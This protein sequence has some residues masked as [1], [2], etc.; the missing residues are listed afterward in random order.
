[1]LYDQGIHR[2]LYLNKAAEIERPSLPPLT[3]GMPGTLKPWEGP[4]IVIDGSRRYEGIAQAC[5]LW[6]VNSSLPP[7]LTPLLSESGFGARMGNSS[8]LACLGKD[9]LGGKDLPS[10]SIKRQRGERSS[11][12]EVDDALGTCRESGSGGQALEAE[13]D[14]LKREL[15]MAQG[16]AKEWQSMYSELH[17][18][19]V[20]SA[21]G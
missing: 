2:I 13:V 21:L 1:V 10:G 5:G 18:A 3:K 7:P 12:A 8:C 6:G 19:A 4:A 14:R 9:S 16:R 15:K 20:Q 17:K 11:E